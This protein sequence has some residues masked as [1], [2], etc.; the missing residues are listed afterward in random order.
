MEISEASG[1]RQSPGET[2]SLDHF[3]QRFPNHLGLG[4]QLWVQEAPSFIFQGG[5]SS[6]PSLVQRRH[7]SHSTATEINRAHCSAHSMVNAAP[8]SVA[9]MTRG[10]PWT[11]LLGAGKLFKGT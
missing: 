5:N 3:K 11:E 8:G 10:N 7:C 2:G 9:T 1:C 4:L 6:M